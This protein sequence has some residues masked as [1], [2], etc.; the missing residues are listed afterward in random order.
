MRILTL[1]GADGTVPS[2]DVDR[3]CLLL[4]VP[5]HAALPPPGIAPEGFVPIES[6]AFENVQLATHAKHA[7]QSPQP[8]GFQFCFLD[9]PDLTFDVALKGIL[10]SDIPG[11]VSELKRRLADVIAAEAVAPARVW[12]NAQTPFFN[13]VTAKQRGPAGQLKVRSCATPRDCNCLGIPSGILFVQEAPC[14]RLCCR[15]GPA[16][17]LKVRHP[18]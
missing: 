16:E 18:L 5:K 4:P 3:E 10:F 13:L 17:R 11:L 6:S 14:R 7:K 2:T 9:K 12:I 1:V 8:T 15:G